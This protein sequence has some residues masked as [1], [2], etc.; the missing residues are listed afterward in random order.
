MENK[1][2]QMQ[3]FS[4]KHQKEHQHRHKQ[5]GEHCRESNKMSLQHLL[6][7]KNRVNLQEGQLKKYLRNDQMAPCV[8]LHQKDLQTSL[9]RWFS[10][11][12]SFRL[13]LIVVF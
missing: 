7:G 12:A 13:P 5:V 1:V 3:D 11:G 9:G 4:K 6:I 8:V 10:G 2:N